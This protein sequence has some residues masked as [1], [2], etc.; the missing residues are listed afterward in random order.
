MQSIEKGNHHYILS[1]GN[2]LLF[3]V[4][5]ETNQEYSVFSEKSRLE[6]KWKANCFIVVDDAVFFGGLS[7][8]ILCANGVFR[9]SFVF[10]NISIYIHSSMI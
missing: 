2:D 9:C 10:C 3:T 1:T 7:N 5:E 8:Q 4:H 6:M